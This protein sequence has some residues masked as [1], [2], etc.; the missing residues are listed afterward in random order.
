MNALAETDRLLSEHGAILVREGR[1]RI[2]K[3]PTGQMFTRPKTPSDHRS[4]L[5]NLASLRHALGIRRAPQPTRGE[6]DEMS[7]QRPTIVKTTPPTA[8]MAAS[9]PPPAAPPELSLKERIQAAIVIE[10]QNQERVLA[11]AQAVE[12]RVNMLKALLPFADDPS[13]EASLRGV[14]PAP[15]PP[16]PP[17][18][19]PSLVVQPPEAITERVQVTRQLVFAATQ[20]FD[21]PFTV[22]DIV[23]R[24]TNGAQID[25]PERLRVRSSVAQCM[26][27]LH[28]RGEVLKDSQGIGRQQSIWR[29]A[30]LNGHSNGVGTRA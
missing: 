9:T 1:H 6:R 28:E 29:K 25:Q 14:L 8:P 13:I 12:R 19:K 11:E 30:Q 18:A 5:N 22:N 26:A 16:P 4:T 2:Y 17:P 21:D 7:A 15:E 10:E 3:L 20:T 24:M 27:T 23:E